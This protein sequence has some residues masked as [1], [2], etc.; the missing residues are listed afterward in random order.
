LNGHWRGDD[1]DTGT[2]REAPEG[3]KY[4]L[5]LEEV[6]EGRFAQI[7]SK[8][9]HLREVL[10]DYIKQAVAWSRLIPLTKE[11]QDAVEYADTLCLTS[12]RQR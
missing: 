10:P 11:Q 8:H 2:D 4:V 7:V 5:K 1:T 9:A 6:S 3:K 12:V